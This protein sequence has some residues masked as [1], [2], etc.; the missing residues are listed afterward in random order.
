MGEGANVQR[1]AAEPNHLH[2]HRS[3]VYQEGGGEGDD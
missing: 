1:L 3:E 2:R